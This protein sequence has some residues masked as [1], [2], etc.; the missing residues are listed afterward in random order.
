MKLKKYKPKIYNFKTKNL[1]LFLKK[2]IFALK[3]SHY[4]YSLASQKKWFK[5]N[6]N[7]D[8]THL[9][10]IL[11]K[12]VIGYNLLHKKKCNIYY[13]KKTVSASIFIFDTLIIHKHF[14][15]KNFSKIIMNESNKTIIKNNRI[16]ILVCFKS[17]LKFYKKFNWRIFPKKRL[18]Y[19]HLKANK[20]SMIYGKKINEKKIKKIIVL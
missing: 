14:R 4:R 2:E 15:K 17:L 13:E 20:F 9:V 10:L 8:D 16:S 18:V 5:K 3:K 7:T 6:I 1:N 12:R 19:K 11:N